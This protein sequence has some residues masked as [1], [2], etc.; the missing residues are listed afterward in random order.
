V[1]EF[2]Q[3]L[4]V[5]ELSELRPQFELGNPRCIATTDFSIDDIKPINGMVLWK[6][7]GLV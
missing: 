3:P 6:Q 5:W 7:Q 4:F 2:W 1:A